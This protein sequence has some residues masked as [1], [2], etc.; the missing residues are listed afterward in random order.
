MNHGAYVT[1]YKGYSYDLLV[2]LAK[3]R[4]I[5]YIPKN[6]AALTVLLAN[7]SV[8]LDAPQREGIKPKDVKT[9]RVKEIH[10]CDCTHGEFKERHRSYTYTLFLRNGR[11]RE[12]R[13]CA[14]DV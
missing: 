5:N 4:N 8:A 7:S 14:N 13:F 1:R 12:V 9:Y 10:V 11:K 2:N 3:K 6:P